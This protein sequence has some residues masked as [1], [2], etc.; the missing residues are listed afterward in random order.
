V[1][2]KRQAEF[3]GSKSTVNPEN[4]MEVIKSAKTVH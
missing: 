3:N 2:T 1:F 4:K